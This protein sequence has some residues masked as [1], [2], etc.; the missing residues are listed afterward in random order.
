MYEYGSFKRI[1]GCRLH[2]KPEAERKNLISGS[3]Q[4]A[5]GKMGDALQG[6]L[7]LFGGQEEEERE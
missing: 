1:I 5:S 7:N 6:F 2:G 4:K 3:L